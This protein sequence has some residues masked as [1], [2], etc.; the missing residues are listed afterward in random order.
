MLHFVFL[1]T[2]VR[3]G[4]DLPEG[5]DIERYTNRSDSNF[6]TIPAG[7]EVSMQ[8]SSTGGEVSGRFRNA[9]MLGFCDIFEPMP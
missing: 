5:P 8:V 2:G 3:R 9:I 7:A 4:V 6:G 1:V